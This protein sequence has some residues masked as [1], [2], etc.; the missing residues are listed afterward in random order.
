MVPLSTKSSFFDYCGETSPSTASSPA[1]KNTILHELC[2][3]PN[4]ML[5]LDSFKITGA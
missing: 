4:F 3:K 2:G 5:C 1:T